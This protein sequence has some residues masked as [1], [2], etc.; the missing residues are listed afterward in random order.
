MQLFSEN[1]RWCQRDGRCMLKENQAERERDLG[2][3]IFQAFLVRR[4]GPTLQTD[5]FALKPIRSLGKSTKNF[6]I[7]Q[8]I[9][10]G[11]DGVTTY[12]GLEA[13]VSGEKQ[14]V[15]SLAIGRRLDRHADLWEMTKPPS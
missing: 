7:V 12:P 13:R 8:W 4:S 15:A 5:G 9:T 11:D 1:Q 10:I 6:Q 3:A 2:S 14:H